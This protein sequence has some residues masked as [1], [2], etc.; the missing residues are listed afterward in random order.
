MF[1]VYLIQIH[2]HMYGHIH[3]NNQAN[4]TVKNR[5]IFKKKKNLPIKK[6]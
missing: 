4:M 1:F 3:A 5:R 6:I 2:I